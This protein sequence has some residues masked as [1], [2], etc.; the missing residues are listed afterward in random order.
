M[1]KIFV[2]VF[3]AAFIAWLY[4]ERPTSKEETQEEKDIKTELELTRAIEKLWAYSP[5]D[6]EFLICCSEE[7]YRDRLMCSAMLIPM[8]MVDLPRYD[9]CVGY[10][11]AKYPVF[12][13]T[14]KG[15][16]VT[17]AV[18]NKRKNY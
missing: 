5:V 15:Q 10:W 7:Y 18:R 4:W 2:F 6:Y 12:I 17:V 8:S 16:D 3:C 9:K 14:I 13:N 11:K 1:I